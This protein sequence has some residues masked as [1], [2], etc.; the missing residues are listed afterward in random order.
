[1]NRVR[2]LAVSVACAVIDDGVG[3]GQHQCGVGRLSFSYY[4]ES[5]CASFGACVKKLNFDE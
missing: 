3:G 5:S 4:G 1:M 2:R